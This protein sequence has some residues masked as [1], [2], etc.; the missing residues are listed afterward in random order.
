MPRVILIFIDGLGIGEKN[1]EIN[2][3]AHRGFKYLDIF[4]DQEEASEKPF[5]GLVRPLDTTLDVEGLPQSAT[6]QTALLCGVNAAQLLK[7]HLQGFPNHLLR[8][9]IRKESLLKKLKERGKKVAFI[10][11]YPPIYFEL[12][13]EALERRLS[14]TSHATLA[15][16]FPFFTFE[17]VRSGRSIYQ[18]FTNQSLQAN[19]PE[20]PIFTPQQAG[21]IL[22]RAALNF[23]FSLYEY[24][25]TDRA[26]HSL[27]MERAQAELL[28]LE[29][30]L[31]GFFT[32][33]DLNTTL[34]LLTSDHGNIEDMSVKTHTRHPALTIVWGHRKHEFSRSLHSII[35][36]APAILRYLAE[37]DESTQSVSQAS[38]ARSD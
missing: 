11:A 23:D 24:F 12:G 17:D 33:I 38:S 26:G 4:N 10:N 25:Q 13:P 5:G 15:A 32:Q 29:Q 1:P 22:A 20:L 6:G 16:D 21:K 3:C 7:R 36:V 28:K 9:L 18:E 14:V 8:Q 19:H 34:V 31:D 35:D 37:V 27:N 30:F 2:P